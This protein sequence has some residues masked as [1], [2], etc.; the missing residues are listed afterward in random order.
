MPATKSEGHEAA[1]ATPNDEAP[2]MATKALKY[3]AVDAGFPQN[4]TKDAHGMMAG[5]MQPLRDKTDQ[6]SHGKAL[7]AHSVR[8]SSAQRGVYQMQTHGSR[9]IGK[10]DE[11]CNYL[12]IHRDRVRSQSIQDSKTRLAL[13]YCSPFEMPCPN[14]DTEITPLGHETCAATRTILRR[15]GL[16]TIP[17]LYGPGH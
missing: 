11:P 1:L 2:G 12:T 8:V 16:G 6:H 3:S 13:R 9:P 4:R 7:P 15:F 17:P 10:A 5:Q 14:Q